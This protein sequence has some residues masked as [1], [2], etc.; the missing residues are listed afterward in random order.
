MPIMVD[1]MS[2]SHTWHM[3]ICYRF[4]HFHMLKSDDSVYALYSTQ[5]TLFTLTEKKKFQKIVNMKNMFKTLKLLSAF[6]GTEQ[7]DQVHRII[8]IIITT[9][10]SDESF[11]SVR[12]RVCLGQPSNTCNCERFFCIFN[13]FFSN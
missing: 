4:N 8:S 9:I 3:L 11:S 13:F 7:A 5:K 1:S 12:R 10:K 2:Y 6:T